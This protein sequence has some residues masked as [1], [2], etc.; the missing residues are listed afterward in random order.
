[1]T[2]RALA[3]PTLPAV[4][5]AA[6]M[7]PTPR[8]GSEARTS[9]PAAPLTATCR[10][11]PHRPHMPRTGSAGRPVAPRPVRR[12]LPKAKGEWPSTH[13]ASGNQAAS[14][15]VGAATRLPGGRQARPDLSR[16]KSGGTGGIGIAS[17]QD[18]RTRKAQPTSSAARRHRIA[19]RTAG[20]AKPVTARLPSPSTLS[21][22][23]VIAFQPFA[24]VAVAKSPCPA[25]LPPDGLVAEALRPCASTLPT[26][27]SAA[28]QPTAASCLAPPHP[29]I[30]A[31]P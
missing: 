31:R 6:P 17:P 2:A 18:I 27:P 19:L 24:L 3:A 8:E 10:H 20:D 28:L 7:P 13:E 21:S 12:P 15:W 25:P 22:A 23:Q 14:A 26:A 1:M 4:D 11:T 30:E 16:A 29:R 9:F 5:R